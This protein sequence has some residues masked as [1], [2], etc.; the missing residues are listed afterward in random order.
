MVIQVNGEWLFRFPKR[1]GVAA[2]LLQIE[3]PL[4]KALAPTLPL[5]IPYFEFVAAAPSGDMRPFAGYF[6]LPGESLA[7]QPLEIMQVN[8]WQAPVAAFLAALHSFPTTQAHELG[9]RPMMLTLSGAATQDW[10]TALEALYTETRHII[11][12][13]LDDPSQDRVAFQFEEFL[14]EDHFFQFRPT[15]IH[16][17]F[18]PEHVLLDPVQPRITGIIDFGDVAI[19]DPAYDLWE[20]LLPYYPVPANDTTFGT[21]CRFY[22]KLAPLHALLFGQEMGDPALIEYGLY[23]LRH[24]WLQP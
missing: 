22:Q 12:P 17:D 9:V 8:W 21:R 19:G 5:P 18:N 6:K 3:V 13:L 16:G 1:D 24:G 15:L 11:Y 23:E 20:N 7:D 10:R 4:L 2:R 14:D